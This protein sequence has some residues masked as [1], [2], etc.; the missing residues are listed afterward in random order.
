MAMAYCVEC[1]TYRDLD[2][3]SEGQW[4][5]DGEYC[6]ESCIERLEAD[7]DGNPEPN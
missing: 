3:E 2:Y 1:D 7:H 6:C 4:N 5:D